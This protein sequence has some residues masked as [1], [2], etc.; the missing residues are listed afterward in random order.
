[1]RSIT[2]QPRLRIP[3][4]SVLYTPWLAATI[5]SLL[6][7]LFCIIARAMTVFLTGG[8]GFVGSHCARTFLAEGWRVRALVR[9]PERAG[10][11]PNGVEV[12]QGDLGEPSTY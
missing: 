11:L 1:M 10:L 3:R 2:L 9:R 5:V 8:T 6:Y 4:S 7:K 12:V